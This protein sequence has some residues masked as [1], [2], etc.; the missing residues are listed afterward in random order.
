MKIRIIY[1]SKY[2]QT[3]KIAHRIV[4]TVT[5]AGHT[6]RAIH[7][8][9]IDEPHCL[10]SYDAV[11]FGAPIYAERH[12]RLVANLIQGH[13]EEL[14]KQVTGFFSVSVSA[15]GNEQQ[16]ADATQCMEQFLENIH[17]QPELKTIFAGG[18]PWRDYN[19]FTRWLMKR[20]VRKAG[21]D[22]DT[23]ENREYT[24][25]NA[26]DDFANQIASRLD[27]IQHRTRDPGDSIVS[28]ALI[29]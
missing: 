18:L 24:D 27:A 5:S 19:W 3:R 8:E 11:V 2:G 13:R 26:V 29:D 9:A 23:S 22:T 15:S 28:R 17:W 7:V 21:G 4:Q 6:A 10:K 12:S 20:I 14:S 1:H 16:R 25:W